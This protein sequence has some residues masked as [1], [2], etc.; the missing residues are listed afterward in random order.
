MHLTCILLITVAL[1][2]TVAGDFISAVSI[3]LH[4]VSVGR[5]EPVPA[6][7]VP[8]FAIPF[9]IHLMHAWGLQ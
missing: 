3:R 5:D 8:N 1:Q 6:N 2:I 7:S 4:S 9:R